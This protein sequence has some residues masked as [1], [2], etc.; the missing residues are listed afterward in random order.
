M[1]ITRPIGLR[2]TLV[3]ALSCSLYESM[4][5]VIGMVSSRSFL[6]LSSTLSE[7][8]TYRVGSCQAP[9]K[10]SWSRFCIRMRRRSPSKA[11]ITIE[12]EMPTLKYSF[13]S[14]LVMDRRVLCV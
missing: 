12:V 11:K 10:G 3:K 2:Y 9:L 1:L 7:G 5:L 13:I 6:A 4:V 14:S 8:S